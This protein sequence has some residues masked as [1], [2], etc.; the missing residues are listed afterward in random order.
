MSAETTPS[1]M[2]FY[3]LGLFAL[4][5][6]IGVVAA[7]LNAIMIGAGWA[8]WQASRKRRKR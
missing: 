3:V 4:A 8:L 6:G 7:Y 2:V 5:I 1:Q